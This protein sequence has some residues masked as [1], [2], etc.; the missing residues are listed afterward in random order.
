[1]NGS[2]LNAEVKNKQLWLCKDTSVT[3]K[4]KMSLKQMMYTNP[5]NLIMH[6]KKLRN[7]WPSL[8]YHPNTNVTK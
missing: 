5:I 7:I 2:K 4:I 8:L 6:E 3:V 1:M